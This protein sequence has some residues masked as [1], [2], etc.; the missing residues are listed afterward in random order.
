[1]TEGIFVRTCQECGHKQTAREPKGPMTTAYLASTCR[2][3]K[4]EALDYGSWGWE[5]KNGN[6]VRMGWEDED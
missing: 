6:Y 1:M 2:E 5:K 3:C 4:S